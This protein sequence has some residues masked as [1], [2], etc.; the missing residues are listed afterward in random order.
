MPTENVELDVLRYMMGI[1]KEIWRVF[2]ILCKG[3][4]KIPHMQIYAGVFCQKW[5]KMI[6]KGRST[7]APN[8]T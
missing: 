4:K 1:N 7:V 3:T 2:K 5:P 8:D 6:Q